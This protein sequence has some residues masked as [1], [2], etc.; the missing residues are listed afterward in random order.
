M[1]S[2][3]VLT[4]R[5]Y[6]SSHAR[7]KFTASMQAQPL[8]SSVDLDKRQCIEHDAPCGQF[9]GGHTE[10]HCVEDNNFWTYTL[11]NVTCERCRVVIDKLLELGLTTVD[12]DGW[13]R[14]RDGQEQC[15]ATIEEFWRA[16]RVAA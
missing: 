9:L 6:P 16:F 15:R 4:M 1:H 13:I 5:V 7:A 11:R 10:G 14:L 2:V 8:E 12:D 3:G